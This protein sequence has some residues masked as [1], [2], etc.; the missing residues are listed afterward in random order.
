MEYR[1][2][3]TV[4]SFQRHR[5]RR[6]S[7]GSLGVCS[8]VQTARS[9]ARS[10]RCT[11]QYCTLP[12]STAEYHCIHIRAIAYHS[13]PPKP[14]RDLHTYGAYGAP[15][16]IHT[17]SSTDQAVILRIV[18]AVT[19]PPFALIMALPIFLFILFFNYFHFY[20]YIYIFFIIA[21]ALPPDRPTERAR[22]RYCYYYRT[23]VGISHI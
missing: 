19:I 18:H 17:Y 21:T 14:S 13:L 5:C 16:H 1:Y 9:L 7:G 4:P 10:L 22:D 6:R 12:F 3:S 8:E 20:F 11:V 15:P 2:S 23:R